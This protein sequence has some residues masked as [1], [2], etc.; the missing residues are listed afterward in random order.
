[1]KSVSKKV[2][3]K[4]KIDHTQIPYHIM[5]LPGMI[6][7]FIFHIIPLGGLVMAFQNFMPI[8]G[9]FKS[10][11]VGLKNFKW[12]FKLPSF[13]NVVVNTLV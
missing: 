6:F 9:I 7:L 4:K 11:F 12:L 10:E 8:K 5:L 3:Y 1:M 2:M 13:W